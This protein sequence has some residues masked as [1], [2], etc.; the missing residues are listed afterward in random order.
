M[1]KVVLFMMVS[2]DGYFEGP[3][4][5][6]SWHNVDNEFNAFAVKNL[7]ESGVLLFGRRTY[8]LMANFWPSYKPKKGDKDDILVAQKMN[9]LPKVVFSKTL[10]TVK[11]IRNWNNVTLIKGNIA[12]EIK[13]LKNQPGK[14]LAVFGSSNLSSSLLEMGLLD[15]LRIMINPVVI[16]KGTPLFN[17]IKDRFNFKLTKTKTFKSGNILLYYQKAAKQKR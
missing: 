9:N 2:L 6:L 13:R 5:D 1:R 11:Q 4:H 14:N 10:K 3:N 16:G 8:E 7:N 12:H 17:G 15:E